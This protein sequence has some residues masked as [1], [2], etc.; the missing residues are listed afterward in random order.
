M[1]ADSQYVWLAAR[2]LVAGQATP[3]EHRDLWTG[4]QVALAGRG[5]EVGWIRA[6]QSCRR[7]QRQG[8]PGRTGLVMTE[9]MRQRGGRRIASV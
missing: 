3:E 2:A 4:I 8:S 9:L 5:V 1:V 6:H 7:R